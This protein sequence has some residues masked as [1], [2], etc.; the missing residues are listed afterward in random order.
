MLSVHCGKTRFA[1]VLL[2]SL[3]LH[4]IF[5]HSFI[6]YINPLSRSDFIFL[7]TPNCTWKATATHDDCVVVGQEWCEDEFFGR[8]PPLLLAVT[9][10]HEWNS[11]SLNR[12]K[13]L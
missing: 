8:L 12:Y 9:I 11:S 7:L 1:S 10:W 3:L 13:A 4:G 5:F 2:S 6:I